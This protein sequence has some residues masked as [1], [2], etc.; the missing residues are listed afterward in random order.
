VI[1]LN[2]NKDKFLWEQHF[3]FGNSS[4]VL[5]LNHLTLQYFSM[6]FCYKV[7]QLLFSPTAVSSIHLSRLSEHVC[8]NFFN[9][10]FLLKDPYMW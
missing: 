3:L 4:F 2:T 9:L 8:Q 6:F 10:S 7:P 5:A 1:K